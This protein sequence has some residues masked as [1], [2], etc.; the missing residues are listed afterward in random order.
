MNKSKTPKRVRP[1]SSLITESQS[2]SI[3]NFEITSD[4]DNLSS[5]SS[6]KQNDA[7]F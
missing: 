5:T 1:L 4:A 7:V 2:K 3:K 6:L